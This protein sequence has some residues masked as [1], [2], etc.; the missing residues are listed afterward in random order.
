MNVAFPLAYQVNLYIRKIVWIIARLLELNDHQ[1]EAI[2]WKVV[3][4]GGYAQEDA[5][6]HLLKVGALC[7]QLHEQT[8]H[9]SLHSLQPATQLLFMFCVDEVVVFTFLADQN[10]YSFKRLF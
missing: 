9:C 3:L 6:N 8:M 5:L 10:Q 2:I 4:T 1:V 7:V